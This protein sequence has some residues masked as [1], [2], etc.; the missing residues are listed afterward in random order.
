MANCIKQST[1]YSNTRTAKSTCLGPCYGPQYACPPN[2]V[3]KFD[4]KMSVVSDVLF[5]GSC[6]HASIPGRCIDISSTSDGTT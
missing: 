5:S 6:S 2:E 3:S 4:A 1:M